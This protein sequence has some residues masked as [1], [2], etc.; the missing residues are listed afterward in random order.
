MLINPEEKKVL[1]GKKPRFAST[2]K[3]I[4]DRPQKTRGKTTEHAQNKY[5]NTVVEK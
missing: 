1:L 2:A 3:N 4:S 5:E